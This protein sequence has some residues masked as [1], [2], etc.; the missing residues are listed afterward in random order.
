MLLLYRR[1]LMRLNNQ[2]LRACALG[3]AGVG[4]RLVKHICLAIDYI[5]VTRDMKRSTPVLTVR[6]VNALN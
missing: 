1:H 3:F 5:L 2:Y 6:V 4:A